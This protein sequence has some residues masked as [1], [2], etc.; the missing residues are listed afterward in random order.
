[1]LKEGYAGGAQN[2]GMQEVAKLQRAILEGGNNSQ[3]GKAS[4]RGRSSQNQNQNLPRAKSPG[5]S[6]SS[7]ATRGVTLGQGSGTSSTSVTGMAGA[8]HAHSRRVICGSGLRSRSGGPSGSVERRSATAAGAHLGSPPPGGRYSPRGVARL[9]VDEAEILRKE[10]V[11]LRE[12]NDRLTQQMEGVMS[13]RY[14][15]ILVIAVWKVS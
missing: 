14:I 8:S 12:K 2:A 5:T 3:N 10:I 9:L 1:M 6:S 13:A 7:H 11:D 4:A 15:R